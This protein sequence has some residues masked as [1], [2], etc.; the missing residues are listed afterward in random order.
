MWEPAS[1]RRRSPHL[2]VVGQDD[3]FHSCLMI[4]VE[5]ST[6]RSFCS[7][8]EDMPT[9]GTSIVGYRVLTSFRLFL[10]LCFLSLSLTPSSP[11]S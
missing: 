8:S 1:G 3:A 11:C 7:A 5:F 10:E 4:M 6:C 2:K 9:T